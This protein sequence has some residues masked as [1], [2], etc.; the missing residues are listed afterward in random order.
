VSGLAAVYTR[1]GAPVDVALLERMVDAQRF[2]GPD[3]R[4]TWVR[5]SIGLGHAL[6]RT[7]VESAREVSP[8]RLED[9][10]FVA[11][12]A[13]LDARD[14]LCARLRD[15]GRDVPLDAPDPE[16]ILAAY[17]AWGEGCVT[18]LLGDFSFA[19]WDARRAR[20]VC[21]VDPLGARAFYYAD[22]GGVFVG[23]NSLVAVRCHA[24]VRDELDE[25]ALGDFILLGAY[26][27]R[28]RTIYADVARVPPGHILVVDEVGARLRRY[29]EWPELD[30]SPSPRGDDCLD[31]FRE[32][33]S[34]AVSDRLRAPKITVAMSGGV[35][36]SLVALTAKRELARRFEA[37]E[38]FA[39]C[40]VYDSLIPDDERRWAGLVARSLSIP[41]DFAVMDR[42][43]PFDWVGRFTPAEPLADVALGPWLDQ[44]DRLASRT[45]VVLTGHD[46]DLLLRTDFPL[47]WRR[48]AERREWGALAR[49]LATY[50]CLQRAVPP[51][52]VRA[53]LARRRRRVAP[54][55]RPPWLREDFWQRAGLEARAARNASPPVVRQPRD[56]SVHA[57]SGRAWG[58]VFDALDP[59]C[60]GRPIEFRHPLLDL[61]VVRFALALPAVPWC[62][63][64]HLLRRCLGGLPAEIARRPKTPLAEDPV[65]AL[66]RNGGLASMTVPPAAE[67]LSSFIDVAA[68][69]AAL[70]RGALADP[71]P[72]L[73]TLAVAT[74]LETRTSPG[75]T[76]SD[77]VKLAAHERRDGIEGTRAR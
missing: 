52:G 25:R 75:S 21:A 19:L 5:G 37:P 15:H 40:S 57:L 76:V 30:P 74:W 66:D 1:G 35:D 53:T 28:D 39:A 48:R 64:K 36:S 23:G 22:R 12:D 20:L 45:S 51:M 61:R 24:A 14:E 49:E 68:T 2:R 58:A 47:H 67:R 8:T 7:T 6:H 41:I 50:A 33:L 32:L 11:A 63:D 55:P 31:E 46:G 13:R 34:R 3:G 43:T 59:G 4:G 69:R 18:R 65:A 77:R 44:L 10:L 38:L 72:L 9:R 17:D 26:E 71:W 60:L 27:D 73:R 29:F 54:L 42:A 62:V 56:A 16:L 70:A